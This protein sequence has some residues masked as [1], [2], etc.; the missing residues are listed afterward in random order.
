M[1]QMNTKKEVRNFWEVEA[2]QQNNPMGS[3]APRNEDKIKGTVLEKARVVVTAALRDTQSGERVCVSQLESRLE[4]RLESQ[5][6][7][8]TG[9]RGGG[10]PGDGRAARSGRQVALSPRARPGRP[11]ERGGTGR[12]R[13]GTGRHR[14]GTRRHRSGTGRHR[15]A[16]ERDR[17]GVTVPVTGGRG[18]PCPP[19]AA[20]PGGVGARRALRADRP[21]LVRGGGQGT[22]A[23]SFGRVSPQSPRTPLMSALRGKVCS[24][25]KCRS[26]RAHFVSPSGDAHQVPVRCLLSL[27]HLPA[28]TVIHR[29]PG[30][31]L[32]CC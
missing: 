22:G 13:S 19:L 32:G 24:E 30:F 4:S 2:L 26:H 10:A 20:V 16:L 25:P 3:A 12:P 17:S 6:G 14:S 11:W 18:R 8:P 21:L 15:G 28:R 7:E 31:S 27:R 5:P 1:E 23:E 9:G 29:L